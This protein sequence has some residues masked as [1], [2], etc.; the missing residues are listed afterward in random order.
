MDSAIQLS[1]NQPLWYKIVTKLTTQGCNDT[2]I[3]SRYQSCWNNLVTSRIVLASLLQ[4][5]NKLFHGNLFQQLRTS[6][7]NTTCQQLVNRPVT[8]CFASLLQFVRFYACIWKAGVKRGW[9]AQLIHMVVS[10]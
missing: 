3:S 4:A 10:I 5:V 8:T 2:V 9:L 7:A 1:Y 6:N